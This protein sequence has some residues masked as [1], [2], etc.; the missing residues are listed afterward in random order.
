[1]KMGAGLFWGIILI[2]IGLSV[3]F[4][5][6]FGISIF[7]IVIAVAFILIGIKL[8]IGRPVIHHNDR[9]TDVFF[10]EKTVKSDPLQG[11]DYNTIFGKTIYDFRDMSDLKDRK[12]KVTFNTV[13]GSTEI[14]LPPELP[15]FVRADAVFSAARLPNGNTV[16]FGSADYSSRTAQSDS[17][18]L[19]IEAHVVFGGLEVRQ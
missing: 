19:Y 18:A 3:I 17:A 9:E 12:T 7:R 2:V 11:T 4:R 14:I 6:I 13:F 1:M 5:V 10:G 15:V 8:L 16:A